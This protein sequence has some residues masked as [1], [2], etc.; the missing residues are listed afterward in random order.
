MFIGKMVESS[1][2]GM[3][4]RNIKMRNIIHDP[5][6]TLADAAFG[7]P[8]RLEL[9]VRRFKSYRHRNWLL[10]FWLPALRHRAM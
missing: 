10:F 7:S 6:E 5:A 4:L 8:R 1:D 9:R 2:K 3:I